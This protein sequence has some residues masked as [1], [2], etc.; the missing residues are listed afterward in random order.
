MQAIKGSVYHITSIYE[1][2]NQ[3]FTRLLSNR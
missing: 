3:Q 2:I 1:V